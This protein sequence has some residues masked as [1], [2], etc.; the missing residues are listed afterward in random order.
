MGLILQ[1]QK[2]CN[3]KNIVQWPT[4][5]KSREQETNVYF[6][7]EREISDGLL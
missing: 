1:Q 5:G 4:I 3:L 6:L 7:E 2:Y